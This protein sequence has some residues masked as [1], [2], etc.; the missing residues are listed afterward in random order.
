MTRLSKCVFNAK[1]ASQVMCL[2]PPIL[3][4]RRAVANMPQLGY[5]GRLQICAVGVSV[6]RKGF[7]AFLATMPMCMLKLSAQ[8]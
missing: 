7:F 5:G 1:R 2:P 8:L 4:G 6:V 3:R